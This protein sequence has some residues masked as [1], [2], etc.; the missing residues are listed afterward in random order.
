MAVS[1]F[2]YPFKG[3]SFIYGMLFVII[4]SPDIVMAISMLLVFVLI[5]ISLGFVALLLAHI[6]FSLPFVVITVYTRLSDFNIHMLEAAKD[7]GA[8]ELIILRKIIVPLALPAILSSWILSFTISMDDVVISSFLTS[9][10]YEIL[11]IKIYSMVKIGISPEINALATILLIFSILMTMISQWILK[12][13]SF[14]IFN[15]V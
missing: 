12:I 7:L 5:G 15:I 11:P 2:T 4:M 9:P 10:L 14:N 13:K 3:K 6:T 1:L 8:S